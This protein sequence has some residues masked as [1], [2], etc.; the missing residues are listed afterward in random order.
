M[1]AISMFVMSEGWISRLI[2]GVGVMTG[3]CWSGRWW[4]LGVYVL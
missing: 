2:L 4:C 3:F 1:D